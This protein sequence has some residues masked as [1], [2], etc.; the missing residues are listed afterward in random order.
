MAMFSIL[1]T[2]NHKTRRGVLWAL[3]TPVSDVLL[4]HCN[5]KTQYL[6][7]FSEFVILLRHLLFF[8][9]GGMFVILINVSIFRMSREEK[10]ISSLYIL[11]LSA[12]AC[13]GAM[14]FGF[15]GNV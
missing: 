15:W 3:V 4:C 12:D 6:Y 13:Q 7:K 1:F 14:C 2:L 9:T 11:K 5:G 8:H 10:K